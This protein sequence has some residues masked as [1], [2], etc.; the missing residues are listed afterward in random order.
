MNVFELMRN[1]RIPEYYDTMYLDGY[2][3]YEIVEA[4]HNK[5]MKRY[6]ETLAEREAEI[7][8]TVNFNV[9]VHNK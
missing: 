7:P 4:A 9:V 2:K 1:K 8:A 5:I 6:Q 3:P